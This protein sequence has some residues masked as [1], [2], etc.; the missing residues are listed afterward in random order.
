[1]FTSDRLIILDA[2]GTTIDA[3]GAMAAAFA[4]HG[5]DIGDLE[6]F[7]KRRHLFKYL[8]GL[9]EFPR[10]LKQHIGRRKRAAVIATLTEIYRDEAE[11]YAGIPELI[12]RLIAAPGLRVG[13][14]TRNI[15]LDAAETLRHLFRRNGID[16]A[17]FDFFHHIPLREDKTEHFR[18]IREMFRV[19]PARAYACGDEKRDFVAAVST[20]MHPFIV[21]Y[22]FEDFDR[23]T[24]KIGVPPELISRAPDELRDRI[25]HALD[26]DAGRAPATAAG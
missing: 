13:V 7:Q 21:S 2:D 1:M 26:L 18:R 5:M 23:L 22:G 6:R 12:G 19:N 15:T 25:A 14:L 3:F 8:G 17:A 16:P 24:T 9:K 20:G 4:R 11:L 10:N